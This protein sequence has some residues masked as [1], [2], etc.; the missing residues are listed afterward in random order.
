MASFDMHKRCA[1]CR[2][3]KMGDDE[4]VENRPCTI[5]DGFMDLQ[6]EMLS[7]PTYKL[8]KEK[9]LSVLLPPEDVTVIAMVEDKEPIS[10][11]TPNSSS[12]SAQNQPETSSSPFVTSAQLKEISDQWSEQFAHF[13]ALL[14]RGNV[15]STPKV[16]VSKVPPQSV[17]SETPFIPPSARLTSPVEFPA[18]GE[19]DSLVTKPRQKE[20]L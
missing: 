15:F 5:C 18:E 13:E 2:D 8:R 6:K 10:H 9:K 11:S 4:C 14:S 17:V 7:T 19:A 20:V 12:S 16:A 3:K 1:R